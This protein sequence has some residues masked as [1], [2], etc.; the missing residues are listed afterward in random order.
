MGR[1][2]VYFFGQEDSILI[3]EIAKLHKVSKEVVEKY[4]NKMLEEMSKDELQN[5]TQD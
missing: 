1:I 3:E 2:G 5:K 4:Y